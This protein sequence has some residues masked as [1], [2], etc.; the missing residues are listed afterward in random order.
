MYLQALVLIKSLFLE[1]K[2]LFKASDTLLDRR[3]N[4][5]IFIQNC[6]TN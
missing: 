3:W 1:E 4:S 5:E 2:R 6:D